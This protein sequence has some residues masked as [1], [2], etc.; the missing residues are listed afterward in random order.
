MLP[1]INVPFGPGGSPARIEEV[2]VFISSQSVALWRQRRLDDPA[3]LSRLLSREAPSQF[4]EMGTGDARQWI[5]C[6]W[7]LIGHKL[8]A[9]FRSSI[10]DP[11]GCAGHIYNDVVAARLNENLFNHGDGLYPSNMA[12]HWLVLRT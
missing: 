7:Q 3:Q 5:I 10:L 11:M 12:A 6:L 8:S 4:H 2:A 1:P 9:A